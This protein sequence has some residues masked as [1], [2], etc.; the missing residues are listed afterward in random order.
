MTH[1]CYIHPWKLNAVLSSPKCGR[2][3]K[4][5]LLDSIELHRFLFFCDIILPRHHLLTAQH[6]PAVYLGIILHKG[7]RYQGTKLVFLV[8]QLSGILGAIA[9]GVTLAPAR[10]SIR[11]CQST[12]S[13]EMTLKDPIIQ[14]TVL[15][16]V[17]PRRWPLESFH[18]E[19]MHGGQR[20]W[21]Q[22][23]PCLARRRIVFSHGAED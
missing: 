2:M 11:P 7:F 19:D 10:P 15:R 21:F 12:N 1:F 20:R 9:L 14:A 4:G 13:T 3:S 8:I 5:H 6:F 23:S 17:A 16:K 18:M 22:L